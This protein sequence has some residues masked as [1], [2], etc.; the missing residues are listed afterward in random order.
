MIEEL[1]AFVDSSA[2]FA[3]KDAKDQFHAAAMDFLADFRG[4]FVTSNFVIDETITLVLIRLGYQAALEIGEQ[5]WKGELAH[6]VRITEDDER[7][8]WALFKRYR[9]KQFSFTDCTSFVVMERLGLLQ[10]FA[11]DDNFSQTGQFLRVPRM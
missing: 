7:A 11:F 5:L 3:I 2:R 9:D 6:I 1:A 4:D 8:A 10:A